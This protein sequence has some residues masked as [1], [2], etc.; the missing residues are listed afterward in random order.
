[1]QIYSKYNAHL[2]KM[3]NYFQRIQPGKL[4]INF[5]AFDL[6]EAKVKLSLVVPNP[7]LPD[8]RHLHHDA[9]L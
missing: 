4:E 2:N 7:G 3:N 8:T 6:E 9:Q 1:M 5:S